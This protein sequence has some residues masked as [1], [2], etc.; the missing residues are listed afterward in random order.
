MDESPA[1]LWYRVRGHEAEDI[2]LDALV[3]LDGR[4]QL[5]GMKSVSDPW[6]AAAFDTGIL[7]RLHFIHI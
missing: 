6:L 1:H 3:Q 2:R 4:L 5:A 7:V